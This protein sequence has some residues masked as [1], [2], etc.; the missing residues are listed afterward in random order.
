[1]F[2]CLCQCRRVCVAV[3][4]LGV[5]A[6]LYLRTRRNANAIQYTF[7]TPRSSI[8]LVLLL[9][10]T[11]GSIEHCSCCL[12]NV[13]VL[14]VQILGS[15]DEN[16]YLGSISHLQFGLQL[17]VTRRKSTRARASEL[18][19]SEHVFDESRSPSVATCTQGLLFCSVLRN[20]SGRWVTFWSRERSWLCR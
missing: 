17:L 7:D 9:H 10:F 13:L 16:T 20:S 11:C 15:K 18:M 12:H 3:A 2:A 8:M 1:M 14:Q 6:P 5:L 4:T 19:L